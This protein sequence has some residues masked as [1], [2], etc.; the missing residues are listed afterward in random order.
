MLCTKHIIVFS[1]ENS[2]PIHI[3]LSGEVLCPRR[4][5][6]HYTIVLSGEVLSP[7]IQYNNNN[8]NNNNIYNITLYLHCQTW[9]C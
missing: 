5:L 1:L 8:N 3:V 6:R 2:F 4:W 7:R 9:P